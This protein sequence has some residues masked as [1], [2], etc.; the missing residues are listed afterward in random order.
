LDATATSTVNVENYGIWIE[1]G[2]NEGT[3][4]Y[5]T[6]IIE[7]ANVVAAFVTQISG[8]VFYTTT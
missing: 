2:D 1:W 4:G 7:G 8:E 6:V 5:E 3:S